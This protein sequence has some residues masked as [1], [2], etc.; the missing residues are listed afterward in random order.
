MLPFRG[1]YR[2][3][4]LV[5]NLLLLRQHAGREAADE[6]RDEEE[7]GRDG[8]LR[9]RHAAAAQLDERLDEDEARE[10]DGERGGARGILIARATLHE[11][12]RRERARH[13]EEA[14]E[15]E[16]KGNDAEGAGDRADRRDLPRGGGGTREGAARR[17]AGVGT[18]RS[19]PS[20]QGGGGALPR[21]PAAQVRSGAALTTKD[22]P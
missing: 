10:H 22:V 3:E 7:E 14:V 5:A 20:R 1:Q 8:H 18:Q 11:V 17:A 19:Q 21:G 9:E 16:H 4:G 12:L 2:D 6:R 15:E 13:G